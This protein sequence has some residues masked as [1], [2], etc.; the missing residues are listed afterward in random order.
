MKKNGFAPIIII[1]VIAILGVAGYFVYKNNPAN[2][3]SNKVSSLP[4]K[5]SDL[6]G[7][8]Q[9]NNMMA[10]G[11]ANRY[12]FYPDG[13]FHFYPNEMLCPANVIGLDGTWKLTKTTLSLTVVTEV[14]PVKNCFVDMTKNRVDRKQP[15]TVNYNLLY[16]G[17]QD[18][19]LYKSI[20]FNGTQYWQ[21][22]T[23][24]TKYNPGDNFAE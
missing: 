11:W 23:D 6:I 4:V 2:T 5:S 8:W 19:D 1:L 24:P 7:I 15:Y 16:L 10:D 20:L 9:A 13:K 14:K 17:K 22:S 18:G 12:H 3:I 21:F